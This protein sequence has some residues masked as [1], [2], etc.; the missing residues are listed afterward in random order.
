VIEMSRIL[1]QHGVTSFNPTLYPTESEEM[2]EAVAQV[3]AAIGR[4]PGARIMGL[5]LEGP[6]LAPAR[7]GV[8]RP[9]TLKPVDI[10]YM[11]RLW[12]ASQGQI[13]NMT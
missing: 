4:E 1:A 5:H 6:F 8:Q 2:V 7:L 12:A 9:E 3:A 10:P 13:V 11:E